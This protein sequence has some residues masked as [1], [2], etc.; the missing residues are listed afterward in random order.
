MSTPPPRSA[1]VQVQVPFHDLD[2]AGIVWHGHYAKYFELARC[3]LLE[4]FDYN[5]PQMAASGYNWPVI[6]LRVRYL[7]PAL[8]AQHL[9]VSA[10]LVEWQYRLRIRYR[11][12]DAATGE[13]MTQGETIQVAVDLETRQMCLPSPTVLLEKLGLAT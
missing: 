7:R 3:A 13:R 1:Q 2:P 4:S 10:T 6:D 12:T 11:I 5:Y 8:F 9:N